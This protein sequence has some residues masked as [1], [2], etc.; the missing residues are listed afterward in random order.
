MMQYEIKIYHPSGDLAAVAFSSAANAQEAAE[1][2][3]S[4]YPELGRIEARATHTW[5]DHYVIERPNQIEDE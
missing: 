2:A 4:R 5:D 3:A 1:I